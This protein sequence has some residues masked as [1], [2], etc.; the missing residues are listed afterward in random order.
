MIV[1]W[2]VAALFVCGALLLTL[3]PMLR[4]RGGAISS[5]GVN[6]ALHR[7]QLQ[8]AERD[9]SNDLISPERFEQARAEIQR[10]ALE[11][12]AAAEG[13]AAAHPARRSAL[14]LALLIPLGSVLTYL[15]IG[16]PE[17][18][19]PQVPTAVAAPV[20]GRHSVSTEQIEKMVTGLAERLKTNPNDAAGWLMLGRSYTA[21]GRY[22]DAA[23]ALRRSTELTPGNPS[24]LAD[25]ADVVGMAQ[26]K[27]LAGEPARLVQQALDLDPRHVKALA[28]A[29][30]VAFEA[31]DYAAARSYWERLVAVLP[32]D[33]PMLRSVSSSIAEASAIESGR[34]VAAQDAPAAAT[35]A[36]IPAA[37]APVKL[38]GSVQ[39]S[40]GL[41]G[42]VGAGDT[43]FVFARAS[44]GAR[45][46]LAILRRGAAPPFEFVLDDSMA[47]SP[48]MRLSGATRVV[49]G[50]RV[51]KS[52][53][54][55]PQPGD[56][57][58]QSE[59]V[60]AGASDVRVL[61][62]RVQP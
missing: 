43:L 14:L 55:T 32:A 54:A 42:R 16:N 29:G 1:F 24:L 37:A 39:L 44:E 49:V 58:G 26:G 46:P 23:I 59:P 51:S 6:L 11:D 57:I 21:L 20:D 34:R 41:A 4:P 60:A 2:I 35:T 53:N 52:G 50:A 9:L 22:R 15:A 48:S 45:M 33:S 25:L 7:D 8:E 18:A 36:A 3:P 56:L 30:S 47:M 40:P 38:S 17:A 19:A 27:R 5:A 61:I 28:L 13:A 12:S 62:D 31:K 10:R